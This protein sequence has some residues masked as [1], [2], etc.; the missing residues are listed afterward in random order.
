VD[1]PA[2]GGTLSAAEDDLEHE[3]AAAGVVVRGSGAGGVR[4]GGA[5]AGRRATG[6]AVWP[7][8][9]REDAAGD[10]VSRRAGAGVQERRLLDRPRGSARASPRRRDRRPDLGGQGWFGRAHWRARA[11]LAAGQLRAGG[12]GSVGARFTTRVLSEPPPL[13]DE[14]GAVAHPGRGRVSGGAVGAARGGRTLLRPLTA[15][16]ER[17]HRRAVPPAGQPAA[18]GRAGCGPDERAFTGPDPGASFAAP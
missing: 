17:R 13:G 2:G 7:G 18:R 3:S 1:L 15:A 10:R 9:F 8:W 12:G 4:R 11:A 6:D 14:Q 5:A 16:A